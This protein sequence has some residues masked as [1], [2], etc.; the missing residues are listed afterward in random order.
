M[1]RKGRREI[2][3]ESDGGAVA[4]TA[5]QAPRAVRKM[6]FFVLVLVALLGLASAFGKWLRAV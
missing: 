5:R 6:R 2:F 1:W 3:V 4:L